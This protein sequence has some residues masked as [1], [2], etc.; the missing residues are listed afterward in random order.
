MGHPVKIDAKSSRFI[1]KDEPLDIK[2]L[3]FEHLQG[4]ID[5][6]HFKEMAFEILREA[7]ESNGIHFKDGRGGDH[8]ADRAMNSRKFSEIVKG[9]GME[10]DQVYGRHLSV[11]ERK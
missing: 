6:P 5:N 8:V 10:K 11:L 1:L 9:R 4:H 3:I 2:V 7:N